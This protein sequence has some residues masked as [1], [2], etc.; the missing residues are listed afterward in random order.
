MSTLALYFRGL[1]ALSAQQNA[2]SLTGENIA[3]THT[4]GYRRR[5]AQFDNGSGTVRSSGRRMDDALLSSRERSSRA[6]LSYSRTLHANLV[7]LEGGWRQ[8]FQNLAEQLGSF[9][10]LVEELQVTPSS[11][12]LREATVQQAD[13][14]AE[15]FRRSAELL[16]S[17]GEHAV[18]SLSD[19]VD[20]VNKL[21]TELS[22]L[23]KAILG[24]NSADELFDQR[25]RTMEQL[26]ALTGAVARVDTDGQM[27]AVLEDGTVL[28][29]GQRRQL[30]EVSV[31]GPTSATIQ[32]ASGRDIVISRGELGAS[33]RFMA[34]HV[35]EA[36][37]QLDELAWNF[38]TEVNSVHR[39]FVGLRGTSGLDLFRLGDSTEG[40]ASRIEIEALVLSDADLLAGAADAASLGNEGFVALSELLSATDFGALG[41]S[42]SDATLSVATAVGSETARAEGQ[43]EE[44]ALTSEFLASA[45]AA[46]SGVSSEEE[47]LMLSTFQ[48]S[49]K[50]CHVWCSR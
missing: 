3:N 4:E 43:S 2:I 31:D 34:T 45:R 22:D 1:D 26:S 15:A 28:V 50:R 10:G 17:E 48:Q 25:D 9:M 38:G 18:R 20:Q 6:D 23:N 36:K 32:D 47:L 37:S 42:L 12:S 49:F 14:V 27:R 21:S 30:L 44:A 24:G 33:Q 13:L 5:L 39:E 8:R 29:D 16:V 7:Q 40:S 19:Q 11:S 46:L 41:G 35:P